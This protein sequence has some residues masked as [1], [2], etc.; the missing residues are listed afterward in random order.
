MRWVRYVRPCVSSFGCGAV[1]D[2]APISLCLVPSYFSLSLLKHASTARSLPNAITVT[3]LYSY[4]VVISASAI[5]DVPIMY[6]RVLN[7]AED[8]RGDP[9]IARR[10]WSALSAV[11]IGAVVYWA[12]V[13][14][15]FAHFGTVHWY[16]RVFVAVFLPWLLASARRWVAVADN[17]IVLYF[18]LSFDVLTSIPSMRNHLVLL[19]LAIA[20]LWRKYCL[21]LMLLDIFQMSSILSQIALAIQI[22]APAIGMTF[23]VFLV[24]A[25]IYSF[26]GFQFFFGDFRFDEMDDDLTCERLID[27]FLLIT[28]KALPEGDIASVLADVVMGAGADGSG[29]IMNRVLFDLSFFVWISLLLYNIVTGL[30]V[31]TFSALREEDSVRKNRLENECFVCGFTRE[32]YEDVGGGFHFDVHTKDEHSIWNYFFFLVYLKEKDPNEMN[33]V[34]T[35]VLLLLEK[36]DLGWIPAR[37]SWLVE[38]HKPLDDASSTEQAHRR[39]VADANTAGVAELAKR[40]DKLDEKIDK[41]TDVLQS[42]A[43]P[44]PRSAE[45]LRGATRSHLE[46]PTRGH[47]DPMT[48]VARTISA[49]R[50]FGMAGRAAAS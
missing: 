21:A 34:E 26:W 46:E 39:G 15:H 45:Q 50:A 40:L 43:T 9:C 18:V 3:K 4:G 28:Y 44:S 47:H 7:D 8:K 22:P 12:S 36:G 25:V 6:H 14:I 23:Y 48:Q 49:V 37:T 35:Y 24:S 1:T 31:D 17:P 13:L 41:V 19:F 16:W 5:S 20:G 30:M 32:A 10:D 27:C 33:G 29:A 42:F 11:C 38:Q 2:V